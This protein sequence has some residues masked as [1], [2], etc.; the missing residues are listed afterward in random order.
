MTLLLSIYTSVTNNNCTETISSAI[1]S[2]MKEVSCTTIQRRARKGDEV[3]SDRKIR[4]MLPRPVGFV[5]SDRMRTN[6]L[7]MAVILEQPWR[8][9]F[10]GEGHVSKRQSHFRSFW[11]HWWVVRKDTK[12]GIK[13]VTEVLPSPYGDLLHL[14]SEMIQHEQCDPPATEIHFEQ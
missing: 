5:W 7:F 8:V 11:N 14:N 3:G 4:R 9:F 1:I 13:T 6:L 12:S 10:F 2:A